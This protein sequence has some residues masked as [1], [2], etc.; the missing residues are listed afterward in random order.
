MEMAAKNTKE[1]RV[2]ITSISA[3]INSHKSYHRSQKSNQGRG[4]AQGRKEPSFH[5]CNG[6]H[7]PNDCTFKNAECYNCHSKGHIGAAYKSRLRNKG[8]DGRKP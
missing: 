7:S 3:R 6:S 2:T 4:K 8:K 1:F 5:G